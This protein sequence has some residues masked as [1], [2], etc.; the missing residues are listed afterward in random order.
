MRKR[1]FSSVVFLY[2]RCSKL[3]TMVNLSFQQVLEE[4][5]HVSYNNREN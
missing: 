3:L 1:I 2:I 4:I 5:A